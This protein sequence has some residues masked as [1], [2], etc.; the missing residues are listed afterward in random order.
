MLGVSYVQPSSAQFES[1]PGRGGGT[2][3]KAGVFAVCLL[4]GGE[5]FVP[6]ISLRA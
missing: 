6:F 1:P 2:G 4:M 3:V 5:V